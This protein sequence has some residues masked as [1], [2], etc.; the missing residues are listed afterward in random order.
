MCSNRRIQHGDFPPVTTE[1]HP[2]KGRILRLGAVGV[3]R[4]TLLGEYVGEVIGET[5]RKH[6]ESLHGFLALAY[7]MN[8]TSNTCIDAK[9]RGGSY[10][11]CITP[12]RFGLYDCYSLASKIS[13]SHYV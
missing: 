2:V 10:A 9:R 4:G 6:R 11:L 3:Q 5:E 1:F 13:P 8:Y 7:T 12:V